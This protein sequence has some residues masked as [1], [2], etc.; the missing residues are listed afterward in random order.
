MTKLTTKVKS[1]PKTKT[2]NKALVS[3]IKNGVTEKNLLK[4][5]YI[6]TFDERAYLNFFTEAKNKKGALRNLLKESLDFKNLTKDDRDWI[7]TIKELK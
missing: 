2:L 5:Y 1:K 3:R 7:I 6:K 4:S